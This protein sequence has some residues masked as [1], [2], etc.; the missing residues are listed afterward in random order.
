MCIQ[1]L[2]YYRK[3]CRLRERVF[4]HDHT[5]LHKLKN[6]NGWGGV[7]ERNL[8]SLFLAHHKSNPRPNNPKHI[9]MYTLTLKWSKI[10]SISL[11]S[12]LIVN[13]C[14]NSQKSKSPTSIKTY[15]HIVPNPASK[16]YP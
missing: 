11:H 8:L 14:R 15:Y 3:T 6:K 2:H 7:T 1:H 16:Q 12:P 4:R 9:S 13:N 5:K 10:G